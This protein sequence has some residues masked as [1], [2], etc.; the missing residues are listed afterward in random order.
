MYNKLGCTGPG[1]EHDSATKAMQEFVY[2]T[3]LP[4]E[5]SHRQMPIIS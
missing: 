2:A 4:R 3:Y 1:I 5:R